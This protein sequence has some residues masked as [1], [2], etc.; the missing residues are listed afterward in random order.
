MEPAFPLLDEGRAHHVLRDVPG[1]RKSRAN[2][3]NRWESLKK[4][5]GRLE[6]RE[7]PAEAVVSRCYNA[8]LDGNRLE[9]I[10]LRAR[11]GLPRWAGCP[12]HSD[13]PSLT[14]CACR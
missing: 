9:D 8:L 3:L 13:P 14:P 10:E 5:S 4:E 12:A 6:P 11:A 7:V 1:L 2:G